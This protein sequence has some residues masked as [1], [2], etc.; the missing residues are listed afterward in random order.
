MQYIVCEKTLKFEL[1]HR[2][3]PE[4]TEGEALLA[5]KRVGICGTD[6]HAFKGNQP[7][8]SYPRILGHE[9]ATEI[10]EISDNPEGLK[11]GDKAVI[12][13]YINCG[14]CDAC[15][16]GKSNCCQNIQVF[17]VHTDGGMQEV[18]SLPTRLLLKANDLDLNEI[19]IVEPLAIGA[20]AIR[21]A[22]VK[23]GETVVV[24][25]CGPIGIGIIQLCKYLG[26]KVIAVDINEHRLAMVK[27]QFGADHIVNA[28]NN[29]KEQ[30][31]SITEGHLAQTVFDATGS[32]KAIEGGTDY[33]K[34]GGS[35]VL[36]GLFKGDL[37]FTHPAIHAKET[38]LMCSRNA[39]LED[40][41]FVMKVLREGKFNT[42]AYI[43]SEVAFEKILTDFD[44]WASPESNEI[45]VLTV[46]N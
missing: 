36:V 14:S 39:T 45:K 29:P 10:L 15:Q 21:R 18:I 2:E 12:M 25:G 11:K 31:E 38:T 28:L 40:F 17:G 7:F 20:H 5:V 41:E 13:P 4:N 34:H 22:D 19:A 35:Y 1:K 26:A 43:T 3:Q 30:I 6:L 27:D 8:F 33:M 23:T 46:L 44:G 42:T 16:S 24:M 9:L 32:K 37:T